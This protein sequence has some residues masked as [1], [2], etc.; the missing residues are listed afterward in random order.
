MGGFVAV[1][2]VADVPPGALAGVEVDG[3]RLCLANVAGRFHAVAG[4]CTH[5]GGPLDQG[6]L[7]GAVLTCPWHFAQFD[8]RTGQVL[9]GPAR[10]ALPTYAVRVEGDAVLV[11]RPG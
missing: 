10:E 11:A 2:R 6:E 9:R 7:E 3:R 8:V 5:I 4:E 1:A